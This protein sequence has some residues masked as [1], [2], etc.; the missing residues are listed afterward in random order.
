MRQKVSNPKVDHILVTGAAGF[1]GSHLV[2]YLIKSGYKKVFSLDDLS[3]GFER[4]VNKKTIFFKHD[5]SDEYKTE[6][7]INKIKPKLLYHLAA[8]AAEGRSQ[9]VPKSCTKRNLVS[10]LNILIPSI[11]NKLKRVVLTSSMSVYG[12][13]Q[14]PFAEEMYPKP[15]DI[16]G[17][18][19]FAMEKSTQVMAEV[20]NFEYVILR[21]HN[22]YGPRQN[23][24]DPYRNVV[25]I[26]INSILRGKNFY[27]Y[28]DGNQKRA[29]TYINDCT[30]YI[31]KAGF[32]EKA[33]RQIINI[34]PEK[35]YSINE[36]A[37]LVLK[38]FFGS[39]IPKKFKPEYL[40]IR[41]QEVIEAY[42]TSEKARI[43]LGYKTRTNL[44][45][46]IKKTIQWAEKLGPQKPVYLK[47]FELVSEKLPL[48]WR[49]NLI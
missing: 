15:E 20:F 45:N 42:C 39:K 11:K 6:K 33:N 17:V 49:D 26:F 34:G 1:M 41:P 4:N 18:N 37:S 14:A 9:F 21:P 8:D 32:L 30:P 5:L 46:G 10:Y 24:S 29:F 47:E 3:G 40:P 43:L 23:F 12:S 22:V 38:V 44:R 28:G 35:E 31:A 16:Y 2:D 13:Q 25:A 19:K 27:I 7:L 36:L 48:T